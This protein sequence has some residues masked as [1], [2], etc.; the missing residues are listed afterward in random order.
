MAKPPAVSLP[1]NWSA[2]EYQKNL[3]RAVLVEGKKRACC[4]WHRRGGKDSCSI[5][6]L[7]VLS[8]M[9]VGTWWHCLPSF[10]QGRKVVWE[11]IDKQGRRI[12]DQAFPAELVDSKNETQMAIKLK[13]GSIYQVVGSDN[14]D[15]LVGTNPVGVV[16]SEYSLANPRAWDFIRPILAENGG[17]AIFIYT[18][19]GKNHGYKLFNMAKMNP[20]WFCES[21][22]VEDTNAIPISV[23]QEE[24]DAGMPE[25]LIRQEFYVDWTAAVVGAFYADLLMKLADRGGC[26][27]FEY[28]HEG[29]ST[30]WDL[31]ISD[32]TAIWF[33]KTG[34]RGEIQIIDC[35]EAHGLPISHFVGVLEAKKYRYIRHW[36]PH[37]AQ[38]R[39]LAT[40]ISIMEQ[41][42]DQGI[43]VAISPK[44]SIQDG[45]Q[46]V[47]SVLMGDIVFHKTNTQPGWDALENYKREY[48]EDLKEFKQKPLHDWSSHYSDAFRYL[49][50]SVRNAQLMN[51][52]HEDNLVATRLQKEAPRIVLPTLNDLWDLRE[53][54]SKT[55]W[56]GRV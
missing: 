12:V 44:L 47:R 38:A 48:D 29:V 45:I 6:L 36:L 51:K 13:N 49:A 34:P 33:W 4:V 56:R 28:D 17:I 25:D 22:T 2:R 21:L 23:V 54:E 20:D 46:A 8:Q 16:F 52:A 26:Y 43:P 14:F 37:D 39:T 27:D 55:Q 30:H 1:N 50:L 40:G 9:R 10:A 15:A 53:R 3:F 7:A 24:R 5:N 11:G 42:R 41:L 35:Y 18:P 19:R 32:S 31:G